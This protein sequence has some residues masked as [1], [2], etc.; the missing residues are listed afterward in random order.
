MIY[1]SMEQAFQ[2][3][4]KPSSRTFFSAFVRYL[5]GSYLSSAGNNSCIKA[6]SALR[7]VFSNSRMHLAPR[8]SFDTS[9]P[10]VSAGSYPLVPHQSF[11]RRRASRTLTQRW[12]GAGRK[13][14]PH[15]EGF[16][17]PANGADVDVLYNTHITA[18]HEKSCVLLQP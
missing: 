7:N 17:R 10:V 14:K 16:G 5:S 15:I 6:T 3:R 4:G 2:T 12:T 13:R 18:K 9:A 11:R 8:E 1:A